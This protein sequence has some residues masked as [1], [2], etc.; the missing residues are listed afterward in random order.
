ME[1]AFSNQKKT[2]KQL[3]DLAK[4]FTKRGIKIRNL[5]LE[6][7]VLAVALMRA[8]EKGITDETA[9]SQPNFPDSLES[10]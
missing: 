2:E 1:G 4:K 6:T 10:L 8:E 3:K 5:Q 9:V 7:G